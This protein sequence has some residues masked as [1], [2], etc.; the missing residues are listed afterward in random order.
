MVSIF[1]IWFD[2]KARNDQV[3]GLSLLKKFMFFMNTKILNLQSSL[4]I[5]IKNGRL[6]TSNKSFLCKL[7]NYNIIAFTANCMID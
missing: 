5:R 1:P 4:S 7:L 3:T 6:C 2:D